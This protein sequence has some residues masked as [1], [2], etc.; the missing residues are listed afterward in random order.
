MCNEIDNGVGKTKTCGD[1]DDSWANQMYV[2]HLSKEKREWLEEKYADVLQF[3]CRNEQS[4]VR[5]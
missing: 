4:E 1:D 2:T 5:L 3:V